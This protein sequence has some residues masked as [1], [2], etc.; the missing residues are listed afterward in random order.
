MQAVVLQSKL[1]PQIAI[2]FIFEYD[3]WYLYS[4]LT[5]SGCIFIYIVRYIYLYRPI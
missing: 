2:V 4:T 1:N 3:G 5:L